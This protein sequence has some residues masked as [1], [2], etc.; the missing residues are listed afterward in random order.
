MSFGKI[1]KI[2][3]FVEKYIKRNELSE[4]A[5]KDYYLTINKIINEGID[6]YPEITFKLVEEILAKKYDIT[7]TV[8][9]EINFTGGINGFPEFKDM[10]KDIEI[11]PEY[12]ALEDHFQKLK[13]LPQPE[14]RTK[15]WY[16]YR[17]N[18]ITASDTA[19]AIDLNP[20][21]PVE[22]FYLKKSDPNYAFLD[23]DNVYHG[24]KFEQVATQIYEHIYNAEVIE[25]GALPSQTYELLGASPD[26]ICSARTLDNKF[27][28]RLGTMLEIKCVVQ[29]QIETS[30]NIKGTI[31]PFYYYCQVQ[32]QLECCELEVC[33]FWQCKIL[34]YNCREDY[35]IDK[36]S[37]TYHTY[38]NTGK[39]MEIAN[40]LKK[41]II[42][43]FY[44][45]KFEPQFEGD[46][47]EWKSKF[48]YAPRLD[49]DEKQYD[50]WFIYTMNNLKTNH[51]DIVKDYYF[52]KV[53][54][55]KLDQ[56]HNQPIKR[57]RA[58]MQA[59]LPVLNQSW[60]RV[61]YY[62][63]NLDKLD[64]LRVI[65]KRRKRYIKMNTEFSINNDLIKNKVLFLDTP[66]PIAPAVVKKSKNFD[67]KEEASLDFI[68]DDEPVIKSTKKVSK[69]ETNI[70]FINDTPIIKPMKN[71]KSDAPKTVKIK[72]K[73]VESD[74]EDDGKYENK[75]ENSK[76]PLVNIPVLK[77]KTIN[78]TEV[79]EEPELDFID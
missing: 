67:S 29:R 8:N 27:S 17:H 40:Y 24:K 65:E 71:I 74:K 10:Y 32:Q 64:E 33:D 72:K 46:K 18:R 52:H 75:Q 25:F 12:Q 16:D 1:N 15:A 61:Q 43:Q 30:G 60:E 45:F 49:M 66:N 4:L 20:Y 21:E 36:R 68:D 14:Q 9:N 62:R 78:K 48:I 2:I 59:L 23:N 19:A 51:P 26:G 41:G 13:A 76:K 11:P 34:E 58:F 37:H 31:C 6:I 63:Q 56:S 70:D 7:Y 73:K 54:Y 79:Y 5:K 57:D 39:K 22:N 55:W 53:I 77:Q 69:E 44:P 38:D 42:L 3:K 47:Q 35:L 28:T 50:E